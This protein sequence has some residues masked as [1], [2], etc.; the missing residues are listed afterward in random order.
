MI[1]YITKEYPVKYNIFGYKVHSFIRAES[2]SICSVIYND[3]I[4]P[5]IFSP[6]IEIIYQFT[7]SE[8]C[9]IFFIF[10]MPQCCDYSII[11]EKNSVFFG[12]SF[13]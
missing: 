10:E 5:G 6:V 9:L 7:M 4:D 8:S 13:S 3:L 2:D 1:G 11:K 12:L